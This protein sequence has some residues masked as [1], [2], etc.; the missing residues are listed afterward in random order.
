MCT[1]LLRCVLFGV[2]IIVCWLCICHGSLIVMFS[3]VGLF[4]FLEIG[5]RLGGVWVFVATD[6]CFALMVGFWDLLVAAVVY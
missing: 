2:M 6:Y 1:G 5:Y 3:L 4:C